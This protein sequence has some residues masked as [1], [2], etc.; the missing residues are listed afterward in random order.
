MHNDLHLSFPIFSISVSTDSLGQSIWEVSLEKF[1]VVTFR[2]IRMTTVG[3]EAIPA[4]DNRSHTSPHPS[5]EVH[6]FR[7]GSRSNSLK[8][9]AAHLFQSSNTKNVQ[10]DTH[11]QSQPDLLEAL[12]TKECQLGLQNSH[13]AWTQAL[14]PVHSQSKTSSARRAV[15]LIS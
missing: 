13:Q 7:D 12:S 5:D 14:H 15:R 3:H 11:S 9:T 2:N 6:F 10:Y 8:F 1:R 4:T